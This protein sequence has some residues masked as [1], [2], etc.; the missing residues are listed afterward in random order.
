[1]SK[2]I[3]FEIHDDI[4]EILEIRSKREG[5]PIEEL[6]IELLASVMPKPRP[7]LTEEEREAARERMRRFAGAESLGYP[8]GADNESIDADLAREYGSSH[9]DE[10]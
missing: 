7:K 2:K 6:A 10:E 4:Y 9:E 1:M 5:R 8:T 3:T